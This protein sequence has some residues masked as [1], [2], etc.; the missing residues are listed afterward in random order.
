MF[1]LVST[2]LIVPVFAAD[3]EGMAA[4]VRQKKVTINKKDVPV[5][6]ILEEIKQQTGFGFVV[7]AG[8]IADLGK[9]T[10]NVKE[11][12]V[13]EALLVLLRGT[14][15]TYEIVNDRITFVLKPGEDTVGKV[16]MVK[17]KGQVWDEFKKPLPGVTVTLKGTSIGVASDVDGVFEMNV[18]QADT[19]VL[20]FSFVGMKTKEIVWRGEK[21]LN[22][23][24]IE[25][26]QAMDEVVVTGYQTLKKSNMAGS[27]SA[28][29]AKDLMFTATN[30]LEQALQGKIA[31]M[32]I[33]NTNGLV[34]SRQK[35]RVRGTSTLLG[36]Q[37]PVWVV[38]GIIQED[39][40]PFKTEDFKLFGQDNMDNFEMMRNFVGSAISWL[41]PS[42]IKDITVLKDASATAIY[43]VKAANGVIVI[44]TKRGE[45][46]SV[47]VTY[48][49]NFS[50]GSKLTYDKMELMNSKERIDVSREI[51]ENG[52]PALA[53]KIPSVG[54]SGIMKR[55]LEDKI[56]YE[57]FNASVKKLETMNTDWFDILYENPFSHSHN[58]SLSGGGDKTT[59][60][61]SFGIT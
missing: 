30:S 20:V 48:S 13:E 33:Q 17:V 7:N 24:L 6:E 55:Y 42:D 58:I 11:V 39:P 29:S 10:L 4:Q 54:F 14:K 31:G 32:V 59:Y 47:S 52:Y 34:G 25:D 26:V 46:G 45:A 21:M 1:L 2:F 56:S 8:F 60:Y 40:L 57:E 61:A 5:K 27:S 53:S 37:E 3:H 38:D 9:R 19:V 15:Y 23:V 18:S 36:S 22:V 43:G 44:T 16:K 12:T 50:I 28:V 49:G 51:Y 41:N 35:V